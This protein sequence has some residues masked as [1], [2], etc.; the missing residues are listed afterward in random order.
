MV[1]HD[2]FDL[3]FIQEHW[4]HSAHLSRISHD[5]LS[6]SVNGMDSGSLL[7]GRPY[8]GCAILYRNSLLRVL[9]LLATSC[10]K[11]FCAIKML[12]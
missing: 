4:L 7:C 8:G 5:F 9:Y 12:D 10:S 3:C 6:V 11:R 1:L 2:S